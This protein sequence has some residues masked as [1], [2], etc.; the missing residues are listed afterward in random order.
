M[1]FF[2]LRSSYCQAKTSQGKVFWK[3]RTRFEHYPDISCT[4]ER[5]SLAFIQLLLLAQGIEA[6]PGPNQS[7]GLGAKVNWNEILKAFRQCKEFE[8]LEKRVDQMPDTGNIMLNFNKKFPNEQCDLISKAIIPEDCPWKKSECFPIQSTA[9]GDC[10]FNSLSR[11][12]FGD[13][14]HSTELRVRLIIEAVRQ[15]HLYLDNEYLIRGFDGTNNKL[16]EKYRELADKFGE[17]L[18]GAY[19]AEVM[20]LCKKGAFCGIWQFFQAANVIDTAIMGIF[21]KCGET[22]LRQNFHRLFL[23]SSRDKD[24]IPNPNEIVCIMW[25]KYSAASNSFDHFVPV[26]K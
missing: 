16:A 15:K 26:V 19:E 25:T 13:Q 23:P 18:E 1:F 5:G 10:F 22:S 11:L 20:S 21:P 12:C 14:N 9:D 6:N 3:K 4:K 7:E 24:E 2:S 8:D 17:S